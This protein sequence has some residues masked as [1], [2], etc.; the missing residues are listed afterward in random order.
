MSINSNI[1]EVCVIGGAGF[2]GSHIVRRLLE[3]GAERVVVYDNLS[4]GRR[5]HLDPFRSEARIHVII[6]DVEN[7]EQLFKAIQGCKHVIHLASNPDISKA[8]SDPTVDF[9]QGTALTNAVLE[10]SRRAGVECVLYASG[11]GVYGETEDC[12]IPEDYSPL[13]PIST[14]GASKLAGESLLS[15]YS[16]MFGIRGLAFR[17]GN[18]VGPHQTHG[19]GHDFVLRLLADP[20]QLEILGDGSQSKPYIHVD[21]VIDALWIAE[22]KVSQLF[23][24]FNVAPEDYLTVNEIATMAAALVVNKNGSNVAFK[25]TGGDRG[26]KGDVPI[27]RLDCSRL[28]SFGWRPS[29]SSLQAMTE[30]LSALLADA[31]EGLLG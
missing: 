1:K 15:A 18:V 19:V 28:R 2:I 4:G 8:M 22:S 27:V 7:S 9:H 23:A 21:D 11:S 3:D 6:D 24:V 20:S 16:S 31:S 13:Q 29:R 14:Y 25:Y 12:F 17:F 26:W 5:S 10:A 30:A